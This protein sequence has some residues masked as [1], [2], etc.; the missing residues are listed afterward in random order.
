MKK[1]LKLAIEGGYDAVGH[2]VNYGSYTYAEPAILLDPLFWQGLGKSLGCK[3]TGL[4]RTCLCIDTHGAHEIGEWEIFWHRFID[5]LAEGKD[6][7]SFFSEL[8]K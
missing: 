2:I 6:I 3:S 1:I 5:H 4:F 7:E 8:I